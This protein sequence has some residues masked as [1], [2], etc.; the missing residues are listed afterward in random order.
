MLNTEKINIATRKN[1]ASEELERLIEELNWGWSHMR[2][3]DTPL[4]KE[5]FF[6]SLNR[7]EQ[8]ILSLDIQDPEVDVSCGTYLLID[9][10]AEPSILQRTY[11][12][13]SKYQTTCS[14]G[15]WDISSIEAMDPDFTVQVVFGFYKLLE[16]STLLSSDKKSEILEQ[17]YDVITN[18]AL[19]YNKK[20]F[21]QESENKIAD[22]LVNKIPLYIAILKTHSNSDF[23]WNS[24]L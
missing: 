24:N 22:I 4:V 12:S 23:A 20:D 19:L 3:S 18:L 8:Q 15:L 10:Y 7:S 16:N 1:I 17:L 6:K 11:C 21:P 5:P 14:F 9:D 13:Q 2:L